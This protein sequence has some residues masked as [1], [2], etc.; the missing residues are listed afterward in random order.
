M[1]VRLGFSLS[2]FKRLT[3]QS[4]QCSTQ[5]STQSAARVLTSL[6]HHIQMEYVDLLSDSIGNILTIFALTYVVNRSSRP[7]SVSRRLFFI[8][9]T[10]YGV[11][12]KG[13]C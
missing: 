3:G 2:S 8:W 13:V 9:F 12:V 7:A 4:H 5:I 1:R 6:R 11:S 10:S